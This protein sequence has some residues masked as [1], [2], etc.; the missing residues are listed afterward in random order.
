MTDFKGKHNEEIGLSEQTQ[1][2][3]ELEGVEPSSKQAAKVLSTCVAFCWLS[4]INR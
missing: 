4:G 2:I 3:V 1:N